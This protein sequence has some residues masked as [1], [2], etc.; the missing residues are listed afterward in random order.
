V[1]AGA[2]TSGGS[3]SPAGAADAASATGASDARQAPSA[4]ASADEAVPDV[5]RS[6]ASIEQGG[7]RITLSI[8][9][10]PPVAFTKLRVR[11]RVESPSDRAPSA[12]AIE[13]PALEDAR[14]SFEMTMPMGD[15]RYRL[16]P[17]SGGW[18]EAEV[19]LPFC[20]SGN[21]RW[22]AIVQATVNGKP[23]TARFRLDLVR[24]SSASR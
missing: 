24:P 13:P 11:V 17:G 22:Y 18:H 5:T 4:R 8:A 12:P 21:P 1:A 10:R 9:P 3:S 7:V 19:V 14:V 23:S 6:D 20:A 15:H 2:A 16:V